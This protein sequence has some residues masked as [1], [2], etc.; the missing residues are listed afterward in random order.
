M[1]APFIRY[2]L[3][4]QGLTDAR[5]VEDLLTDAEE[6]TVPLVI[7]LSGNRITHVTLDALGESPLT[8]ILDLA[9]V[10]NP[11]GDRG[12]RSLARGSTFSTVS[13]LNLANT[14]ITSAGVES[15][16]SEDSVLDLGSLHLS[17]NLIGDEGIIAIARSPRSCYLTG[18]SINGVGMT[19]VGAKALADSP[20]LGW[21]ETLSAARNEIT[22]VGREALES[23]TAFA[24]DRMISLDEDY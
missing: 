13:F 2:H 11:I 18:L 24:E 3:H 20:H 23:S 8:P 14:G 21:L 17:D 19:D 5:A 1:T 10:G 12:A 7:D 16:L 6:G 9:L 15:L 4:D 22:E